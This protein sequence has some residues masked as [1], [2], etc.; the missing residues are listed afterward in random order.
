MGPRN[1]QR[2]SESEAESESADEQSIDPTDA[3]RVER[4]TLLREQNQLLRIEGD[5]V[6][7]KCFKKKENCSVLNK[8][9]WI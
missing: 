2:D 4:I 6:G 9:A 1:L 5:N 8:I 7:K 3:E